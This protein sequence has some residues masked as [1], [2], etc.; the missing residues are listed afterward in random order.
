[1]ITVPENKNLSTTILDITSQ[2]N[3][4]ITTTQESG[5]Y[6]QIK[7]HNNFLRIKEGVPTIIELNNQT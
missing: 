1:M 7:K 3:I 5:F 6:I 4:T 2:Y